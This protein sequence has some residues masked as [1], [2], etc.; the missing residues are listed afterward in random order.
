[1]AVGTSPPN[2]SSNAVAMPI[3][4]RDFARKNPVAWTSRSSSAVSAAA[5]SAGVG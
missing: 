5:R 1:M 2:R 3:N 4:E